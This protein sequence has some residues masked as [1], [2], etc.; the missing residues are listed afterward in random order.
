MSILRIKFEQNLVFDHT[1]LFFFSVSVNPETF[2]S[3]L[4]SHVKVLAQQITTNE[5][6]KQLQQFVA[7]KQPILAGNSIAIEQA[8]ELARINIQWS[9]NRSAGFVACLGQLAEKGYDATQLGWF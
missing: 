9:E 5:E 2:E 6:L 4:A 1:L 8:L 3:R 7:L